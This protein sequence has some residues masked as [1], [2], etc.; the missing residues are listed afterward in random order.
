M[1][2]EM[3]EGSWLEYIYLNPSYAT[4]DLPMNDIP[5]FEDALESFQDFLAKNGHPSEVFWVFRD[6]LWKRRNDVF[7]NCN[8]ASQNLTLVN[9]IFNEGRERGLVNLLAIASAGEQIVATIWFPKFPD[10]Q[11]QGWNRGMKFSIAQPLP[12]AKIVGSLRW[13][14]LRYLPPFRQYQ[15][16]EWIIGTKLWATRS[17]PTL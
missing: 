7:V 8:S 1:P 3:L 9:K 5:N 13:F 4:I 10:E 2:H 16:T 11:V 6:D 15:K 17:T 12:R 14:L